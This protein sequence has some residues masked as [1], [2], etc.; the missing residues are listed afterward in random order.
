MSLVA[1]VTLLRGRYD[2]AGIDPT[3]PEAVPSPYRLFCALVA[4]AARNGDPND[5][6]A[7]RW[8]EER[9]PPIV[10][11][12]EVLD[13]GRD[14]VYVVTNAISTKGGSTMHPARTNLVRQRS[15]VSFRGTDFSFS[16]SD[17]PTPEILDDLRELASG[18]TYLGRVASSARI[19]LAVHDDDVAATAN[20]A[21]WTAVTLAEPGTDVAVPYPGSVDAL[22]DAHE[23]GDRAWE[24]AR[25]VRY[26]RAVQVADSAVS[27][28]FAGL[29]T[30]KIDGQPL[31]GS[32]LLTATTALRAAVIS[33]VKDVV[34]EDN[35]P[36]VVHGHQSDMVHLSYLGL[37]FVDHPYADGELRGLAVGLPRSLSPADRA[38]LGEALTPSTGEGLTC[39]TI[40]GR[41][42]IRVGYDPFPIRPATLQERRW[43]GTA[44]GSTT[45]ATATPLMLGT[46]PR[47]REDMPAHVARACEK[48]GL[49]RPAHVTVSPTP[50]VAGGVVWQRGWKHL[51]GSRPMRPVVHA[52][53]QFP[54][55]VVGPVLLGSLRYLGAG[56]CVPVRSRDEEVEHVADRV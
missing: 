5:R 30:F 21:V 11:A 13:S 10:A 31:A 49:P 39:V 7:L 55:P 17:T 41:H 1:T 48:A 19:S 23:R 46:F 8:L 43:V 50:M 3:R 52:R 34:G 38:A 53:M 29:L 22:V 45:W 56:L 2:A 44:N 20:T 35:V 14:D 24:T 12:P 40:R 28:P 6:P 36:P 51:L 27:S 47:R 32:D 37:P 54:T 9:R 42:T 33:R 4:V 15:W 18:V 26:A 16:W 25:T